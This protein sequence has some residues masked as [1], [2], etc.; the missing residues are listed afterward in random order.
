MTGKPATIGSGL[1][2][3]DK[4]VCL[5]LLLEKDIKKLNSL[6]D[7][8]LLEFPN[9]IHAIRKFLKTTLSVLSFFKDQ[10]DRD[11]YLI[12]KSHFKTISKQYTLIRELYTCK[13]IYNQFEDKLKALDK[14][15][16]AELRRHYELKNDNI[17][18]D[19]INIKGIIQ[20]CLE[21]RQSFYLYLDI[22]L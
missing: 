13:K 1:D 14:N 11:Q 2:K 21:N 5:Q 17:V 4:P 12:S 15:I 8:N 7:E 3:I 22:L 20:S 19:E 16:V 18:W 10:C 6:S 9:S